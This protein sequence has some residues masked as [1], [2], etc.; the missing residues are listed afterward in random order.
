MRSPQSSPD[1]RPP[2][3]L[4]V[5]ALTCLFVILPQAK[6]QFSA[7]GLDWTLWQLSNSFSFSVTNEESGSLSPLRAG[8]GQP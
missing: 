6:G 5:A 8:G 3:A 4:P 7:L 2:H 1:V